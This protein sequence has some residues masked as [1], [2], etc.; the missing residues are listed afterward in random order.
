MA[1]EKQH[2]RHCILY[3]HQLGHTASEAA[4][5]ICQAL[6][7][8]AVSTR[9]CQN[10]FSR[11][12]SGDTNLEDKVRSGR[13]SEVDD[14]QLLSLVES[15]P[16][17]TSGCLA[18]ALGCNQSTVVRHLHTLG[19]VSKLGSWIPHVLTEGNRIARSEACLNLLSRSRRF[20]WLNDLLTGDEKWVMYANHSRK[21]QWVSQGDE[22]EPDPKGDLH[23]KKVMLSL[24]FDISGIVHFELLP[25]GATITA[26]SYCKQLERLDNK[27]KEVRPGREKVYYLHDNAR[28]HIAKLTRQKI[29]DLGWE[30]L[31]HPAY[32]PD[33]SP[34]DYH[35]FRSL[36][37]HLEGM[38]F[39]S[40]DHV[41]HAL[42]TFFDSK[43]PSFYAEGIH[44]LPQR[45]RHIV[46]NDGAYYID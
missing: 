17:L 6:G 9:V 8:D 23:P 11:F 21:R 10:W 35:V 5:N 4:C 13:P 26:A 43:L 41:E 15:D 34:C 2:I 37:N 12:A 40:R 19:K 33:I 1:C 24:W 39:D 44:S 36:Q 14:S 28:P 29:L 20:D 3:E 31:P 27:L 38:T 42:H 7:V 46:D 18:S 45:W 25:D 30:T 16:R 22:P 32:S